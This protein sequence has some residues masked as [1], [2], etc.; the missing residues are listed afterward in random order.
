MLCSAVSLPSYWFCPFTLYLVQVSMVVHIILL[1][2]LPF[3]IS[4]RR[5]KFLKAGIMS[6]FSVSSKLPGS[7]QVF[8]CWLSEYLVGYNIKM[9]TLLFRKLS[10][11]LLTPV[12]LIMFYIEYMA[13]NNI[14]MD[15]L[16]F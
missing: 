2:L 1:Y 16:F 15:I 4:Q 9:T 7:E 13:L 8:K 14:G 3:L 10:K 5:C 11:N 6:V 12:Y